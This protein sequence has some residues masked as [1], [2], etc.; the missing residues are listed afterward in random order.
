MDAKQCLKFAKD[1]NVEMVDFR[2]TD[3]PGTWQHCS[4]PIDTWDEGTFEEGV[5]FDGSSIRGWQAINAS[6][7]LAVPDLETA[8]VV[9]WHDRTALLL[10]DFVDHD[11]RAIPLSPRAV[12]RSVVERAR[13]MGF[14]PIV[15]VEL[16][17]YLLRETPQSVLAKRPSQ[18]VAVEARPSVYG[19]VAASRQEPFAGSVREIA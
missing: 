16:E 14:E 19:V 9:P 5:G 15:G 10:C 17:F 3:W 7:M 13:S 18:L 1:N 2:F 12:L 8:R 4:Y 11:G 6:D